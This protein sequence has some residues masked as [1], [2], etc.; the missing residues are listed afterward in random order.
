M[1]WA[2]VPGIARPPPRSK[3]LAINAAIAAMLL[4]IGYLASL[5]TDREAPFEDARGRPAKL[6]LRPGDTQD[7]SWDFSE[8]RYCTEIHA[9]RWLLSEA[10]PDWAYPLSEATP[11]M[12]RD[13]PR[14]RMRRGASQ[15]IRIPP[16]FPLLDGPTKAYFQVQ[17][18]AACNWLQVL[19]PWLRV[20][21][22]LPAIEFT[23]IPARATS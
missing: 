23:V 21:Y 14:P 1:L 7:I 16:S 20:T 9:Y 5:V 17:G 2:M 18:V 11:V 4:A 12:E 6:E 8:K 19:L 10:D 15:E 13:V 22:T 3:R